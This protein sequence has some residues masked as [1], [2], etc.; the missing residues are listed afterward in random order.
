[1]QRFDTVA[2]AAT[3]TEEGFIRDAPIVGRTGILRYVNADGSERFEYRPPDEAF[4]ADSLATLL[5][6]PITIGHKAMVDSHNASAV[7]P[8][9]TV[10]SAGR[11]D[12]DAIR[13]DIVIYNLDTD[14]RELSCGYRL[15]LDETPG[16]TP[17]GQH[18]DAVQRNIVYNHIAIVPKGRAGIARLNMDGEQEIDTEDVS[19]VGIKEGVKKDMADKDMTKIRLDGGLEYD[20]APEVGVYVEKLRTEIEQMRKDSEDAKAEAQK[21]VDKMQAKLDAAVAEKDAA[22]KAH[23]DAEK[24]AKE[25]FDAAVANRVKMLAVAQ[26]NKIENADSMTDEEIK[27][28]VI[29]AVRGD[30]I[31]L[32]GKSA[33][34]IEAAFDMAII[35]A[36]K[37]ADSMAEQ[38]KN[39][40]THNDQQNEKNDA[41][42]VEAALEKLKAAEAEMYLKGRE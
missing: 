21:V 4:K 36:K 12:G 7:K 29:K 6:K 14:A 32:D 22:V 37:R 11:Q 26:E 13:A 1:M 3:M 42:D 28:A 35:D 8:I 33:D 2:F 39:V 24:A 23:E 17:D 18:Y 19:H 34:Y 10:L 20:A 25:N 30:A 40:D 9:G 5:G 38:R 41:D 16:V 15:D 27:V 31:D